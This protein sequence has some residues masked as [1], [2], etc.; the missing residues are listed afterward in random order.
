MCIVYMPFVAH[1]SIKCTDLNIP[2]ILM[3]HLYK[4][5]ELG[6]PNL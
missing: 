2:H 1:N 4:L 6:G 3:D 5:Q